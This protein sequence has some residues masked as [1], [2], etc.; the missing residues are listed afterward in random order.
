[1]VHETGRMRKMNLF[2]PVLIGL[3]DGL[4]IPFAFLAG[5]S[6]VLPDSAGVIEIVAPI[7]L[8]ASLL[9]ALGGFLTIKDEVYQQSISPSRQQGEAKAFYE[10][11]GLP[12][13]FQQQAVEEII[14]DK[15]TFEELAEA[16]T[17]PV[18][19]P[20][21]S[22]VVIFFSYCLAGLISLLPYLAEPEPMPALRMTASITTILLFLSGYIKY[23]ATNR[24]PWKGALIQVVIGLAAAAGAYGI[25]WVVS[26]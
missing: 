10:N 26:G 6:Q 20:L 25:G 8:F 23:R 3:S 11:I 21:L 15:A 13:E 4:V 22:S 14:K 7:T 19:R 2:T 18:K 24:N 12:A 9:L 5:L 17:L 16:E 1:M